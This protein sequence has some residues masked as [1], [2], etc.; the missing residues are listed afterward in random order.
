MHVFCQHHS[1]GS[2]T[3]HRMLCA[4][5]YTAQICILTTK[6]LTKPS[7]ASR[8]FISTHLSEP[9]DEKN[10]YFW[11]G[12]FQTVPSQVV[13]KQPTRML[14]M[15]VL[16][17]VEDQGSGTAALWMASNSLGEG[18]GNNPQTPQED[19]SA[20]SLLLWPKAASYLKPAEDFFFLP[21]HSLSRTGIWESL[22]NTSNCYCTGDLWW[23][24][25]KQPCCLFSAPI[26]PSS[27][28][29]GCPHRKQ[30][31][32]WIRQGEKRW[33]EN[34]EPEQGKNSD[35]GMMGQSADHPIGRDSAAE[36]MQHT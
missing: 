6:G 16:L 13:F 12:C 11:E 20:A 19:R 34:D 2:Y 32:A 35:F 28:Q 4:I 10:S 1:Q 21:T 36:F 14:L 17:R 22:T 8:T 5:S 24:S 3:G 26:I 31:A 25:C 15:T 30:A 18:E 27:Y 23:N 7:V 9:S 33:G 29:T